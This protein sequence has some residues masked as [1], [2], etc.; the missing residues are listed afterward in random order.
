MESLRT[1]AP[2]SSPSSSGG[3]DSA[4]SSSGANGGEVFIVSIV[5]GNSFTAVLSDEGVVYTWGAGQTRAAS[6]AR[7]EKATPAQARC[8]LV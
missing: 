2:V 6:R 5:C 7:A 3:A 8:T 1:P 4:A